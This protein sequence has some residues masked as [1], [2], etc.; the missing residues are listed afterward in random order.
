MATAN[1]LPAELLDTILLYLT[2]PDL[3]S[4]A[5]V[6]RRFYAPAVSFIYSK[7]R[8]VDRHNPNRLGGLDDHDDTNIIRIL[9]VLC[10][11]SFLASKVTELY[12]GCQIPPPDIFSFLPFESFKG[13]TLSRDPRLCRILRIAISHMVNVQTLTI[14]HGHFTITRELIHGFFHPARKYKA[15]VRRFWVESSCLEDIWS[16]LAQEGSVG[17]LWGVRLRRMRIFEEITSEGGLEMSRGG[18]CLKYRSIPALTTAMSRTDEDV[19][20]LLA[21][22]GEW[23]RLIYGNFPDVDDV[24]AMPIESSYIPDEKG[25]WASPVSVV[26]SLFKG[27]AATLTSLNLD[28]LEGLGSSLEAIFEDLPLFPNLKAFQIRNAVTEGTEVDPHITLFEPDSLFFHFIRNH[29]KIEYLA[30]PMRNF[31]PPTKTPLKDPRVVEL[32]S[33]LGR[34]LKFLRIDARL[35][36]HEART[37][38]SNQRDRRLARISRRYVIECFAPEMRCLEGL[39]VEGGVPKDEARELLRGLSRCPLKKLVVLGIDFPLKDWWDDLPATA[40][41]AAAITATT[42]QQQ[43]QLQSEQR[44]HTGAT[45]FIPEYGKGPPLLQVIQAIFPDT[46][47]ELKFLGSHYVFYLNDEYPESVVSSIFSPLSRF[48]NLRG[49]TLA[50]SLQTDIQGIEMAPQVAQF[51]LDSQTTT[52]TTTTTPPSQSPDEDA[53]ATTTT[54][55]TPGAERETYLREQFS[56]RNLAQRVVDLVGSYLYIC[57]EQQQQQQPS[58]FSSSSSSPPL[59]NVRAYLRLN[60]AYASE[61]F[62]LAVAINPDRSV[63]WI[64]GPEAELQREPQKERAWF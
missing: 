30:W 3:C 43:Q 26:R 47:E 23:D 37:D 41:A 13:R 51:W 24:A 9:M 48:K 36:N 10:K 33:D 40:T 53:V 4:I 8:L 50:F 20:E 12:Y 15:P 32:I 42:Q 38:E 39:K 19:S 63:A 34:R 22:A 6:S 21:Q 18:S 35:T 27:A 7:I 1:E 52:A 56:P 16:Y 28:W 45:P 11:N 60:A 57:R 31:F 2:R 58:S 44:L 29:R 17:G 59:V 49:L 64:K 5:R 62:E 55:T 61:I 14:I 25:P 46:I 54:T